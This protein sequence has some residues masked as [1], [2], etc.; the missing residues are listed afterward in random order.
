[1]SIFV[2][3]AKS[4]QTADCVTNAENVNS[5][6]EAI[7]SNFVNCERNFGIFI[8]LMKLAK[9]SENVEKLHHLLEIQFN[10]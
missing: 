8:T 4:L 10:A 9:T 7:R 6:R 2:I 3:T 5:Y 1:M